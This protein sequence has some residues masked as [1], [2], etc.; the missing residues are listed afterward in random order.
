MRR[1][2]S[3]I[4]AID[5][6]RD[7][8]LNGFNGGDEAIPELADTG[9]M[10]SGRGYAPFTISHYKTEFLWFE[11]DWPEPAW[12]CIFEGRLWDRDM[13]KEN[14]RPWL[15]VE[16][17]GVEIMMNEIGSYNKTPNDVVLRWISDLLD[18]YREFKWGYAL[19]NFKGP[20]GLVEHS[21]P[22]ARY[23]NI[24]GFNVDRV[25]LEL[26]QKNKV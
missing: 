8:V 5:P 19:W 6:D 12:P 1:A 11:Y 7:L 4:R 23:E 20:Y 9:A 24:D 18:V 2:I 14:Y 17:M 25:L 22:G 21:K 16:E 10:H 15:E 13:L 26:L 3:A